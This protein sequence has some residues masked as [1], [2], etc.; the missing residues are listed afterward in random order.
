MTTYVTE[1]YVRP[2]DGTYVGE[3]ICQNPNPLNTYGRDDLVVVPTA[4]AHAYDIWD[5]TNSEWEGN[6]HPD[7]SY[8]DFKESAKTLDNSKKT[9][10]YT[11]LMAYEN[12]DLAGYTHFKGLA[13]S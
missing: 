4:P 8:F 9:D 12:G 6:D 5:F 1:H 10:A 11:A 2:E 13:E 7:K 3:I